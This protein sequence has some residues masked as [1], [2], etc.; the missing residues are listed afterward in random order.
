MDAPDRW[1]QLGR[2]LQSVAESTLFQSTDLHLLSRGRPST[3]EELVRHY[4]KEEL[5]SRA[6]TDSAVRNHVAVGCEVPSSFSRA[7][8]YYLML[9]IQCAHDF[10][11][12]VFPPQSQRSPFGSPGPN[13]TDRELIEWLLIDLWERRFDH[14]LKLTA[15]GVAGPFAFY[16]IDP[17]STEPPTVADAESVDQLTA[18]LRAR[19]ED[20]TLAQMRDE[21]L[22]E[23][24][25]TVFESLRVDNGP[26]LMLIICVTEPEQIEIVERAVNL[27]DDKP[28]SDWETSTLQ[29]MALT[30]VKAAG[31]SY[32]DLHDAYGKRIAVALCATSPDSL[33]ILETLFEMPA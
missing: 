14:W 5:S 24:N 18:L 16:G 3:W 28:P 26:R 8:R 32:E 15:I 9:R 20:K 21:A 22:L 7:A 25:G 17:A 4:F 31:L 19:W 10:L 2:D 23:E 6:E 1:E 27:A 11:G 13:F 29:E 33:R 12:I 30:T